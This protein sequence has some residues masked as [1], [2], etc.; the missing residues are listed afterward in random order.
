MELLKILTPFVITAREGNLDHLA[1]LRRPATERL[2]ELAKRQAARGLR[3]ESVFMDVLH[4]DRILT[5]VRRAL[6]QPAPV[7]EPACDV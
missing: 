3:L 4:G 7:A 1:H 5:A 2:D 6:T